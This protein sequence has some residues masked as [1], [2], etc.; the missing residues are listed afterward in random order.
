METGDDVYVDRITADGGVW[1]GGT[2]SADL[3]DG[4]WTFE[5][6]EPSWQREGTLSPEA[7]RTLREAITASGFFD[8]APEHLP[9][10]AVI[11][12]S[13]EVWTA[14]VDGRRHTSTLRARGVTHAEPLA[15][16]AEALEDALAAGE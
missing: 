12:A 7:L 4:E 6:T 10:S 13:H 2:V 15:R 11:H 9:G 3:A 8:T 14:D 1:T 16:L 5:R